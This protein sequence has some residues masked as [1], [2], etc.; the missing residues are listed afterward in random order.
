M[1]IANRFPQCVVIFVLLSHF[2]HGY[3]Y[4]QEHL[5][6][7][8]CLVR[9]GLSILNSPPLSVC[10]LL[11]EVLNCFSTRFFNFINMEKIWSL[12]CNG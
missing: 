4:G 2:A 12:D 7:M 1:R 9:K 6:S 8:P 11:M 3:I 5:C 10:K